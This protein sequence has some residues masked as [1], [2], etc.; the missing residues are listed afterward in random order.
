MCA[1]QNV[2]L[3]DSLETEFPFNVDEKSS[4]QT[5][6]GAASTAQGCKG[7]QKT[8][9]RA[10][11]VAGFSCS[12]NGAYLTQAFLLRDACPPSLNLT[13]NFT[14]FAVMLSN[15]RLLRYWPIARESVDHTQACSMRRITNKHAIRSATGSDTGLQ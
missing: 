2:L 3:E 4:N 14:P 11:R 13:T 6:S 9:E 1:R 5:T 15:A 12:K 8:S 7:G 10:N